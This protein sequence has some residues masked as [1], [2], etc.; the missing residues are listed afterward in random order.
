MLGIRQLT[1]SLLLSY[2]A[3]VYAI[4]P[5]K[6]LVIDVEVKPEDCKLKASKG[7]RVKVHYVRFILQ[8]SWLALL[9][10]ADLGC[11]CVCGVGCRL[12]RYLRM[13]R[14]LIPVWIEE[15]RLV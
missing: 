6:E 5:P 4:E 13:E 9:D 15:I 2:V 8:F 11:V 10:W 1:I 3:L 12:E 7:D 14:S